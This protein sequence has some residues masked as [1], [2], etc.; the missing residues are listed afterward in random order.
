MKKCRIKFIEH[1]LDI[2]IVQFFLDDGTEAYAIIDT[3][4]EQ[5]LFDSD[6]V[7]QHRNSIMISAGFDIRIV[8]MPS[9]K[10]VIADIGKAVL[11]FFNS[12]DETFV[13]REIS[14]LCVEISHINDFMKIRSGNTPKISALLGS[15]FLS[16]YG[17]K[18]DFKKKEITCD[19]LSRKRQA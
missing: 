10:N 19:D 3:G 14:G 8:G 16:K 12:D 7:H 6:F 4:S 17:F 9:A 15:D 11:A 1:E 18:L 2:P 5:T 13:L